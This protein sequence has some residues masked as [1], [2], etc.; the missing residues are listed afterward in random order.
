MSE[1][2]IE[3][4]VIEERIV[5]CPKCGRRNRLYKRANAGVYKCGACR[6]TLANPFAA[7]A[8]RMPSMRTVGIAV[9]SIIAFLVLLVI[10]GSINSV[11]RTPAQQNE[12]RKAAERDAR[13]DNLISESAPAALSP[14]PKPSY[15][16][17]KDVSKPTT[18]SS[19]PSTSITGPSPLPRS[20]QKAAPPPA[21]VPTFLPENNEILFD[22]HPD[23]RFRGELAVDNGTP[24]HAV[25]KL[26][27]TQTDQKILSF[28]IRAH[29][30]AT[31]YAIPD[32]N[33]QLLFA[34]G[35]QLYVGTDRFHSS[36][37]FSKFVRPLEYE[38]RVEEDG[39]GR[40]FYW[41][42]LSV[43][44]HPVF[45]GSAKTSPISQKEFERY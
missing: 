42:Q 9:V 18:I 41:S 37:G 20:L 28:I 40:T 21:E 5:P 12:I 32:G 14:G 6:A 26:I 35:D 23:S 19:G 45:A 33:Y 13:V 31:I 30:K 17:S 29:Q 22:A 43:T 25:A 2:V 1:R 39:S 36:H 38:T 27:D 7:R 16:S 3:A 15:Y 4:E 10:I 34:F 8:M 24:S 11:P 44:L